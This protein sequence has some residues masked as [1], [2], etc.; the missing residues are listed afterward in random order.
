M[1]QSILNV[2]DGFEGIEVNV[3]L[4]QESEIV[5]KGPLL[6]LAKLG[7]QVQYELNQ[8]MCKTH[9]LTSEIEELQKEFD[10][11]RNQVEKEKI[12]M[13]ELHEETMNKLLAKLSELHPTPRALEE[14]DEIMSE[15]YQRIDIDPS[16]PV[17]QEIVDDVVQTLDF[18]KSIPLS[19]LNKIIE[20]RLFTG[21]TNLK[22]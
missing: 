2:L 22:T 11:Y 20:D 14:L 7:T 4:G 5:I 21:E 13:I 18:D 3:K 15:S 8:E 16:N 10:R 12:R 1:L 9:D 17:I 19:E 6:R